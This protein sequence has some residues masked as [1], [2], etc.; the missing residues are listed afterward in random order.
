MP[1]LLLQTYS[2][3]GPTPKLTPD[4]VTTAPPSAVQRDGSDVRRVM[5]GGAY[6]SLVVAGADNWF[7]TETWSV[8]PVPRPAGI[9]H[10]IWT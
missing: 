9:V 7:M 4:R 10:A 6:A 2:C 1:A 3:I 8:K 5:L